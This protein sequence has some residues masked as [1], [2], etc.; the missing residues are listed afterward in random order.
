MREF[1]TNSIIVDS[2]NCIIDVRRKR[3]AI[4]FLATIQEIQMHNAT[5]HSR[6]RLITLDISKNKHIGLAPGSQVRNNCCELK[7][8]PYV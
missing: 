7:H 2:L 6:Q 5:S 1:L 3:S 4:E 8:F